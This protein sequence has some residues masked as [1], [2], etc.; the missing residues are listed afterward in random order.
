MG[1]QLNQRHLIRDDRPDD[2]SGSSA[3]EACR[4]MLRE[5]RRLRRGAR[6]GGGRLVRPPAAEPEVRLRDARVAEAAAKV[7]PAHLGSPRPGRA[8]AERQS[9]YRCVF[10]DKR[11]GVW[12]V[13]ATRRRR[14]YSGGFSP[15]EEAAA[16]L[17]DELML[18]LDG[19]KA[20][21]NFPATPATPPDPE[22]RAV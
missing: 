1:K 13:Q 7:D 9:R 6:P 22:R 15:D 20:R 4:R 16:R 2:P 8:P 5:F 10:W 14:H 11:R 12:H 3:A 19:P 21:L 18:R 17:A